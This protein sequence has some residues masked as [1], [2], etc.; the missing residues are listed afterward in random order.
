MKNFLI[1]FTAILFTTFC[2]SQNKSGIITYDI[3][4]PNE[5]KNSNFLKKA[6]H[7]VGTHF[8]NADLQ[9]DL[10]VQRGRDIEAI[11]FEE[12]LPFEKVSLFKLKT[13]RWKARATGDIDQ[14]GKGD[15]ILTD[16]K[17]VWA[18]LSQTETL[19]FMFVRSRKSKVVGVVTFANSESAILLQT[20][21]EITART[22]TPKGESSS[23]DELFLLSSPNKVVADFENQLVTQSKKGQI[24]FG[25]LSGE[26]D[27]SPLILENRY[28]V[29]GPK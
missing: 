5:N 15:I 27:F 26:Q 18:W 10:V 11:L 4:Y 25:S 28:R 14:D 6:G 9:S 13:G 12:T 17:E 1:L 2:F 7:I 23:S 16:G 22:V 24:F 8:F 29:V 21:N 3:K 20:K 19:N